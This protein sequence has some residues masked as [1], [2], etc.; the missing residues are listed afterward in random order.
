MSLRRAVG[1][2]IL[3]GVVALAS[4]SAV[5]AQN[6]LP[7][8]EFDTDV[9]PWITQNGEI[10]LGWA[11]ID[12]SG[13]SST[14][15]G[16]AQ[17]TNLAPAATQERAAAVCVTGIVGGGAYSFGADLRFPTGQA[18][19]GEAHIVLVWFAT[20]ACTG[21]SGDTA[22]GD[23]TVDTTSAGSWVRVRN[24]LAAAP[25]NAQSASFSVRLLKNEASGSLALALDGAFLVPAAGFLFGDGCESQS[26]C[27]WS[28]AI[29]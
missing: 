8:G 21:L 14:I 12:H 20:A 19:T 15:S 9:L 23:L 26:S 7:N 5:R 11:A 17:A 22:F 24:D 1:S 29:P 10:T 3:V 16:T 2:A 13:C 6:I 4:A 18:R 25:A 28:A 27:H